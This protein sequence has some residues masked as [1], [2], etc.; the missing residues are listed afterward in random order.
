MSPTPLLLALD[1]GTT[2][3][4]AI[5]F[6][7]EGRSLATAQTELPQFFPQDGWVEHDPLRIA[8]DAERVLREAARAAAGA[9]LALGLTNQRETVVLWERATG[10]PLHPAIVWQDRRTAAVCAR[11]RAAGLEP[12][13]SRRTG[14][15]LDPYFSATKIAWLLDH[16]PG[17]RARAERG[18]LA[19]GTV[20]CWLAWSLSGG[21]QHVTD[22]SNASRTLLFD[23][24]TSAWSPQL[25]EW[26]GVPMAVLPAVRDTAADFGSVRAEVLGA[27]LPLRALVGD[28]Q[29]A[30]F[31]Q[32]CVTPGAAK[33]TF[34]TGC[35][36]LQNTGATALASRN[37]L[38]TTV[39]WRL[40][41]V[42]TFALEGSVFHAGSVVQWLRDGLGLLRDASEA[43][44]RARRAD[45]RK[46]IFLVPAFTG[47]GAP[48]WRPDA[49]G[50][51]HGLTRDANADDLVRAGLEAACYQTVDLLDAAIA[52]GAPPPATLRVDGGMARSD[53]TMQALADLSGRPVQRPIVT[54]TTALG[55]AALAGL[56]AGLWSGSEAA[57]ALWRPERTFTPGMS[58]DERAERRAGWRRAVARTLYET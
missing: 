11:L 4:R 34:G 52:D 50:A 30:A 47:L 54:E 46:R 55:A 26:F 15:L 5:L 32:A 14:L 21:A 31:G 51:I 28:Q 16:V 13:I 44:A 58:A 57:T 41:G 39:A 17:A 29:A 9:P 33:A 48:W 56:G 23:L 19:V 25:C 22:A 10:R 40:R 12:E 42:A 3:T 27:P 53:W 36:T 43:D 45:P 7:A 37:R 8:G 6:D 18:E 38:L 35:F 24:H 20:D 49:R 1:A 2:S